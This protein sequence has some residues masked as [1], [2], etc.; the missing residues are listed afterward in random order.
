MTLNVVMAVILHYFAE[1]SSFGGQ[2]RQSGCN[3]IH[4]MQQNV[5]QFRIYFLAIYLM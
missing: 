2:L 5:G 1:F 3:Y 4:I